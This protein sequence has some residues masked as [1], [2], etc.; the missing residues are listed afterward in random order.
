MDLLHEMLEA[1]AAARPDAPALT[2]RAGTFTYAQ[3]TEAVEA[4]AAGLIEH[5]LRRGDRVAVWLPKRSEKAIALYGAMRAGGVA[6]PVNALLKAPQVAHILRDSGATVL[7]GHFVVNNTHLLVTAGVGSTNTCG[8]GASRMYSSW[9]SKGNMADLRIFV[10]ADDPL[11]HAG[12]AS[13]LAKQPGCAVVGR[14]SGLDDL[15]ALVAVLAP[16]YSCGT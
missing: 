1:T 12:L 14:A 9:M 6:V 10:I 15:P 13:L 7:V 2:D 5:G 16:T 8:C 4:T 3:V 11:A